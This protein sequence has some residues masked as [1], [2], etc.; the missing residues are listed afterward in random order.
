MLGAF[1]F[2]LCLF[3]VSGSEE[4]CLG[5]KPV[6]SVSS[7]LGMTLDYATANHICCNNHRGAERF[8]YLDEPQVNLFSKLDPA[9]VHVFYDSVCGI[10]LFF[11]PKGRPF[12]D[13][14]EESQHHG[15]P[16]FR[17][18][19]MV[20]ENVIIHDGGRMESKCGTH[21]GHNLPSGGVDRYCIDLVCIAGTAGVG[22]AA[23]KGTISASALNL[24]SYASGALANSGKE[25]QTTSIVI[26]VCVGVAAL[27]VGAAV[28][29]T[30]RKARKS[31]G[32]IRLGSSGLGAP[33]AQ[34]EPTA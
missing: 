5:Q 11:A 27:M 18:A 25:S 9:K 21:L 28:F 6:S 23:P 26:G 7:Y 22:V 12:E 14:K 8:G 15:W 19:E 10:P 2:A 20:S 24:T 1:L 33:A 13:F 16:S 30:I 4:Q 29:L 31:K 3:V 32:T 17:P 34:L